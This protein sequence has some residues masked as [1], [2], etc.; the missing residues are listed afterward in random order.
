MLEELFLE[1]KN[2]S[3]FTENAQ[4][5][6]KQGKCNRFFFQWFLS[7]NL[8][9]PLEPDKSWAQEILVAVLLLQNKI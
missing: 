3:L 4:K 5:E 6:I 1:Y 2:I 9:G 7:I 8:S